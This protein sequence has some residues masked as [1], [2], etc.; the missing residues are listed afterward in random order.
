MSFLI[1]LVPPSSQ[2]MGSGIGF[3]VFPLT[4]IS[5]VF[6]RSQVIRFSDKSLELDLIGTLNVMPSA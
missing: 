4:I 5:H 6:L 2:H 1:T 3:L